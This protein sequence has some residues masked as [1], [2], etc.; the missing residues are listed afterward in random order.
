M[1]TQYD[2]ITIM[3]TSVPEIA[4]KNYPSSVSLE[5]YATVIYFTD[6]TKQ[7]LV[8]HHYEEAKR[9]FQLAEKLYVN[10]DNIVRLL[11]KDSFIYSISSLISLGSKNMF[12]VK[13]LLPPALFGLFQKQ[14]S[15]SH[16]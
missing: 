16:Q 15:S 8:Q 2:A 13:A 9:C 12:L 10:G 7:A 11:M 5:I 4:V 3:K 14:L 1:I 6:Y